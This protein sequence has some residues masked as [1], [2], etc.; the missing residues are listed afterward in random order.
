MSWAPEHTD[1]ALEAIGEGP[2]ERDGVASALGSVEPAGL[3]VVEP[4][5]PGETAF[6]EVEPTLGPTLAGVG[7]DGAFEAV[8]RPQPASTSIPAARNREGQ[9][10]RAVRRRRGVT[11]QA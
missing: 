9:T 3:G 8:P 10:V 1:A 7:S 4:E 11:R 6:E 5:G 2:T